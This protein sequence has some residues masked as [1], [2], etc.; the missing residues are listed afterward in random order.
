VSCTV[1]MNASV[2]EEG[3]AAL[4]AGD[5]EAARGAFER[6]LEQGE[7][8]VARE[9]LGQAL[10]LQREYTRAT[11]QQE[12]AYAAYLKAGDAFA[13]SRAA[14]TLAWIRPWMALRGSTPV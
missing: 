1:L 11:A 12:R 10:Y 4:R 5:A 3:W 7:S 9:G 14:R 2:I 6:A 13:T 8:G